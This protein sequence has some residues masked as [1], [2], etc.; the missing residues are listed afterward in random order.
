MTL[1]LLLCADCCL[2]GVFIRNKANQH[3]GWYLCCGLST[4]KCLRGPNH[5]QRACKDSYKLSAQ[6]AQGAYG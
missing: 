4:F 3:T 2:Y 1:Q 6:V 5:V